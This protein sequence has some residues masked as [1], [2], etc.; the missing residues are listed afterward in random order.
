MNLDIYHIGHFSYQVKSLF[1][2]IKSEIVSVDNF[3]IYGTDCKNCLD[4]CIIQND[5]Y[6]LDTLVL[7]YPWYVAIFDHNVKNFLIK[8]D[9]SIDIY[10]YILN[11]ISANKFDHYEDILNYLLTHNI[12][13]GAYDNMAI[14][15][16]VQRKNLSMVKKLVEY[17]ANIRTNN[18][19]MLKLAVDDI[20]L[21]KYIVDMGADIHIDNDYCIRAA[22]LTLNFDLLQFLVEL[23]CDVNIGNGYLL[24][25]IINSDFY[26]YRFVTKNNIFEITKYLLGKGVNVQ[27]LGPHE[28]TNC[29]HFHKN[30]ELINLLSDYGADFTFIDKFCAMDE[31]EENIVDILKHH[32][33]KYESIL[34]FVLKRQT[35]LH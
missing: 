6:L 3:V 2:E 10:Q 30:I 7:K 32:G 14:M 21:F 13:I 27:S 26:H 12:D 24:R 29:I 23:G 19:C 15:I 9:G 16:A 31:Y 22:T 8:N 1:N 34:K 25:T 28:L 11:F 17:G 33:L 20:E 5:L 4:Y 35:F 18:D